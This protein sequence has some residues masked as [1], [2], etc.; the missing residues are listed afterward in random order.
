MSADEQ[1]HATMPARIPLAYRPLVSAFSRLRQ[2]ELTL[3]LPDGQELRFSG[4]APG[5][6]A[7][8]VIHRS[9]TVR[10]MLTGGLI[11]FAEAYMDGDWDSPDLVAL[12]ELGEMNRELLGGLDGGGWLS[13]LFSWVVH[14]LRQNSRRGSRRNIA[15]HYDLGNAFYKL[16]L[17]ETMTYSSA[18]FADGRQSLADAQ[19]NKYQHILQRLDLQA[20]DH[21]LEIGSGW[22]GFAIHAAKETGCRV[23]SITLSEEQL[24]EARQRAAAE[25]LG[26]RVEFRLQDYRDLEGSFDAIASIEMFEAVGEAYWS[27]FFQTVKHVLKP[28]GRAALQVITIRDDLFHDYRKGVDFIQRY[29]FPGGMLPSPA[30]FSRQA[31]IAG[32]APIMRSFHG[33]DYAA[34]LQHWDRS[35]SS[36][37][38]RISEQG[39]DERFR[40]MWH[41]YLAYCEA[42]FRRGT[43]DL[44]QVALV[45]DGDK[46]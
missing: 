37:R 46:V 12:I 43:I 30:E 4:S 18:I 25:G 2:G 17:D 6:C 38:A 44:M 9:R 45:H 8:W 1:T 24:S 13:R 36:Q 42:G 29:I 39:F 32:L 3:R 23:T 10:R 14:R 20:G 5:P 31:R 26:D 11:G 19:R 16:W 7:E 27:S 41:Y 28:G 22:G 34:T 35:F 33:G 40:R 21:L 15:Y